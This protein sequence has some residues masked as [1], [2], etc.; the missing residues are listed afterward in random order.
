M[1]TS[2]YLIL[3]IPIIFATYMHLSKLSKEYWENVGPEWNSK[4]N[5]DVE[6]P[7]QD[8]TTISKEETD[9]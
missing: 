6:E 7:N 9:G 1:K 2:L 5:P 4:L 3:I 8:I